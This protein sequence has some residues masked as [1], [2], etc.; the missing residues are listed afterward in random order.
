MRNLTKILLFGG[1]NLF[2]SFSGNQANSQISQ[3]HLYPVIK[4]EVSKY[5][6]SFDIV[7]EENFL[8]KEF[9]EDMKR[10][11]NAENKKKE[12]NGVK[13]TSQA[14]MS[15]LPQSEVISF[16]YNFYINDGTKTP[17]NLYF[18]LVGK[19][20]FYDVGGVIGMSCDSKENLYAS[21]YEL[22]E[23]GIFQKSGIK[24]SG[25]SFKKIK[26][27]HKKIT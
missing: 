2:N 19:E 26:K 22:F 24:E 1:M 21:A 10:P 3:S 25:L 12:F 23:R 4:E 5:R 18:E 17:L 13:Y 7:Q 11:K 15:P 8:T 14:I 6:I 16:S 9:L 27:M 20:Q